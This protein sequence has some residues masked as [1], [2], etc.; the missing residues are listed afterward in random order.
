VG[1]ELWW[2]GEDAYG[3][4]GFSNVF[5]GQVHGKQI[6]GHWVDVPKGV[7]RGAGEMS[8]EIVSPNRLR[9]ISKTG[10]FGGSEWTRR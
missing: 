8:L 7:G 6:L 2:Y 4:G 9:A 1:D 3:G 10:N 5:H